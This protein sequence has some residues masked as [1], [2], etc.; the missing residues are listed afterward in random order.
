MIDHYVFAEHVAY[1]ALDLT[2]VCEIVKNKEQNL[3]LDSVL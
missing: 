1:Q 3:R 2:E